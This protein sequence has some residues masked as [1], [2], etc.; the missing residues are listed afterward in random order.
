MNKTLF[1]SA[2]NRD[3]ILIKVINKAKT[4]KGYDEYN[5]IL[6]L[7]K[8]NEITDKNIVREIHKIDNKIKIVKNFFSAKYSI[9][10]KYNNNI[11]TGFKK[12]FENLK[13]EFV[14]HIED[15]ILPAYDCL[16]FLEQTI[17]QH[18]NDTRYFASAAF[19]KEFDKH[20][21]NLNFAYSK[22]IWGIGTKGWGMHKNNWK[23]FKNLVRPILIPSANTFI[24]CHIEQ[25]LK[26]SFYVIMPYRSR[27]FELPSNGMNSKRFESGALLNHR[28]EWYKSFLKKKTYHIKKYVFYNYLTYS[29]RKDCVK[30][31]L[32]NRFLYSYLI[33]LLRKNCNLKFLKNYF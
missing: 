27:S 1:I 15:D 18:K 9:F 21:T 25:V 11:Y 28:K 29:W 8:R 6:V 32:I 2:Y 22:F 14:I 10:S 19:S 33:P 30:Y 12:G 4:C 16:N 13:S 17:L 20:N 26:K 3:K 7:Q 31:T 5:K 23:M 24:D